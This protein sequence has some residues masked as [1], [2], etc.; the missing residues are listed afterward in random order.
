LHDNFLGKFS[1]IANQLHDHAN[2]VSIW[3]QSQQLAGETAM[4][5]S[6]VGFCDVGKHSSGL[7]SRKAIF[8]VLRQQCDLVYGLPPVSKARLRLWNNGSMIGSTRA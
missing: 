3:Q 7:L 5:Y 6:V 2:H 4:P 1:A 8:D